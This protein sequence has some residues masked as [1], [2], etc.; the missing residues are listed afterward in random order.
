MSLLS[1][2][3]FPGHCTLHTPIYPQLSEWTLWPEWFENH[4]E[5]FG[6]YNSNVTCLTVWSV[7]MDGSINSK[8]VKHSKDK[9]RFPG[10]QTGVKT[11]HKMIK[12]K[13]RSQR[14]GQE[15]LTIRWWGWNRNR[16]DNKKTSERKKQRQEQEPT[17]SERWQSNN[18]VKDSAGFPH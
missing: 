9:Q 3:L 11:A 12:S 5:A 16:K 6:L 7:Y 1:H 18:I 14:G 2:Q 8:K 4:T 15:I 10:M 17:E 13:K